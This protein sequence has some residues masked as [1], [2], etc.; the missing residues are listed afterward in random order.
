MIT[1]CKI[2]INKNTQNC[3]NFWKYTPIENLIEVFKECISLNT[4]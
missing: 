4:A 2:F 3:R 1:C